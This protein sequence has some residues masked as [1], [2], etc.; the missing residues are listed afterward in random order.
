MSIGFE[1]Q[2]GTVK[3]GP[4]RPGDMSESVQEEDEEFVC[5][6]CGRAMEGQKELTD[7]FAEKHDMDGFGDG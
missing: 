2:R 4:S 5:P 3:T 1:N 7:H 6:F